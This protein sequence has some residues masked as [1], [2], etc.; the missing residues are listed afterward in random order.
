MC[1]AEFEHSN[2][3]RTLLRVLH[4]HERCINLWFAP[5]RTCLV[6]HVGTA[7][8]R[9]AW[10]LKRSATVE[11]NGGDC[12]L[13]RVSD[14]STKENYARTMGNAGNPAKRGVCVA[15]A[16]TEA[17]TEQVSICPGEP[18]VL[19]CRVRLSEVLE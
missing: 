11:L 8:D 4:F 19:F 17:L 2:P 14:E 12:L 3:V 7:G 18:H 13:P 9:L 1:K 16:W 5:C 6:C 15:A 10:S